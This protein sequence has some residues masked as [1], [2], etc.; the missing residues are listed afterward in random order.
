[1]VVAES[2]DHALRRE[3]AL[4]A[5][6]SLRMGDRARICCASPALCHP[7]RMPKARWLGEANARRAGMTIFKSWGS[8]LQALRESRLGRTPPPQ[9]PRSSVGRAEVLEI[10]RLARLGLLASA[11]QAGVL[12]LE[13]ERGLKRSLEGV[14]FLVAEFAEVGAPVVAVCLLNDREGLPD[15]CLRGAGLVGEWVDE[16]FAAA[17]CAVGVGLVARPGKVGLAVG[18]AAGERAECVFELGD[19]AVDVQVLLACWRAWRS[20]RRVVSSSSSA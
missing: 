20:S 11:S 9:E 8:L 18:A 15:E 6:Q 1:M 16:A 2:S 3:V 13:N 19:A 17:A 5:S 12:G 10:A 4:S 14:E 7:H